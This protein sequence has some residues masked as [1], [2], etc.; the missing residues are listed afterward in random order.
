MAES[1]EPNELREV[2][3]ENVRNRR[4][5]LGLTQAQVA[6]GAGCSQA[7]IAQIE[8]GTCG[9][10][11]EELGPLARALRT[12]AAALVTPNNFSAEKPVHA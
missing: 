12:T 6:K 11:S 9:I 7:K 2:I 10:P 4:K 1:M 3:R 5:E 8:G